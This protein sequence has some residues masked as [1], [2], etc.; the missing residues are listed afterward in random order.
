MWSGFLQ[1]VLDLDKSLGGL[2]DSTGLTGKKVFEI[3]HFNGIALPEVRRLYKDPGL[4][5]W[6]FWFLQDGTMKC[7][8]QV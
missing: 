7:L 4:R 2:K 3:Y 6:V 1:V 8:W 5:S